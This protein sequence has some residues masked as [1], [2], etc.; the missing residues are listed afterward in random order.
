MKFAK[1]IFM[2]VFLKNF[3]ISA[4]LFGALLSQGTFAAE[5]YNLVLFYADWN[6]YSSHA[7]KTLEQVAE[8]SPVISFEKIN[9]DDK[10]A[11][12]RMKQLGV[13]P[14][15][16]IPYYFLMDKNKKVIYGS[17]YTRE[18][19]KTIAEILNKKIED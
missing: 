19:A 4:A 5:R 12:V 3:T 7:I 2:K 13:M 15:N 16:L 11:F 9:I 6:V 1:I 14:T 17:T 8:R 18:N 10:K